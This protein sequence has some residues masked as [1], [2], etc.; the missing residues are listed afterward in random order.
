[1]GLKDYFS[2]EGRQ[3]MKLARLK[4]KLQQRFGQPEDRERAA[5]QLADIGTDE[6]LWAMMSRFTFTTE[7]QTADQD[8]KEKIHEMLV[9]F[10]EQS[11]ALLK[12]F[13]KEQEEVSWALK[14]LR[15]L[16]SSDDYNRVIFEFLDGASSEE[17]DPRKLSELIF[18]LRGTKGGDAVPVLAPMLGDYDDEV[19]FAVVET[20]EDIG[21]EAAR[22]PLLEQLVS[23]DE[24]SARVKHRILE[25]LQKN[26]W[27]VKGFR[28]AV[29]ELLP[30][31]WYLDRAGHIKILERQQ[32]GS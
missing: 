13:V 6:A 16:V 25:A 27:E 3:A 19:R 7:K 2:A 4:K 32:Q 9:E 22:E 21:H 8:E 24:D 15:V 31:D 1:M 5:L 28:K 14:T 17:E 12:R 23:E 26:A 11:V 29:E 20:L 18:A 30:E 10:G